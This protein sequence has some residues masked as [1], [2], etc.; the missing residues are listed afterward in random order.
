M[1]GIIGYIG[2]R[3]AAGVILDGLRRLE[4]RGYDSAGIAVMNGG[5]IH[6]DRAVGKL[7]NLAA[8]LPSLR[9]A[10]GVDQQIVQTGIGHTRWATH[11]GVTEQNAH[12][13]FSADRRVAVVQN[14]IVENYAELKRELEEEGVV[15]HSE[16]DT[17]VISHLIDEEVQKGAGLADATRRF[18][19]ESL[20]RDQGRPDALLLDAKCAHI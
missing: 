12:P 1:C 19:A 2:P 16:T 5:Q 7:A 10:A 9:Q 20:D 4:Y 13:H 14:G 18:F 17:E 15:F 3:D 8:R 11:G 6:A